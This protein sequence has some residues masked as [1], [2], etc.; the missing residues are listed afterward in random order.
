MPSPHFSLHTFAW[1]LPTAQVDSQGL[2]SEQRQV[3]ALSLLDM[4]SQMHQLEWTSKSDL[5]HI[6]NALKHVNM[7]IDDAQVTTLD[8]FSFLLLVLNINIDL[9]CCPS[10]LSFTCFVYRILAQIPMSARLMNQVNKA[11]S[12]RSIIAK[13]TGAV[14]KGLSRWTAKAKSKSMMA[15]QTSSDTPGNVEG[16]SLTPEARR[17]VEVLEESIGHF[18]ASVAGSIQVW[19]TKGNYVCRLSYQFNSTLPWI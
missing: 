4:L 11:M 2:Q 18:E 5:A 12:A 10:W 13:P 16:A 7:A 3:I 9:F 15:T 6:L 14:S 1:I 19:G 17:T 8:S